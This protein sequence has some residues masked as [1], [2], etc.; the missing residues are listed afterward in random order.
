MEQTHMDELTPRML[1]TEALETPLGIDVRQP[2]LSWQVVAPGRG[3]RQSGYQVQVTCTDSFDGE[4][5]LLW[6]SGH[7]QSDALSLTLPATWVAD[8]GQRYHWRVRVWDQGGRCSGWSAAS[9]WEMGLLDAQEWKADWIEAGWDE[10]PK[11]LHPCPFLR[12]PFRLEK[13]VRTARLL[14][15]AHG[16]YEA[17]LNGQRVGDQLFTP[18]YTAYNERLQY[19]VYDV[20]A[21][22]QPGENVLG[23]ILGDGWYRGRIY[24]AGSRNVYGTRL[25]LLAQ[26]QLVLADGSTQVVG[27]DAGWRAT[28]GP[29]IKSDMREGEIYDAR[30][31]LPGWCVAGYDAAA[32][33]G[34]RVV[35]RPSHR[36]VASLGVPV[37]RQERFPPQILHT[38]NGETVLDFGQNLAGVVRMTVRGPAGTVVRLSHG[39]TLGKDGNF[40]VD[41]L[42]VGNPKRQPPFQEICY[43][44]KGD[45]E[46]TYEP[47]FTVHG[48]RYVKL[49]GHPGDPQPHDFCAVA[50]YSDMP[51]TGHFTC[52][53]P[54]L[55]QL[56]HNVQWSMKGNFLD[57]PTDCPQRERAGWTGD[58]QIFA[59]SASLLMDT[60]AFL[61]KWLQD[62]CL[63]QLPNGMVGNFVPNPY[64]VAQEP[65]A[66]FL[67]LIN[68][69]AGWGDVTTLMPWALYQAY[70][71]VRL[72]E[73][74]YASMQKWLDYVQTRARQVNW[75]RRLHPRFWSNPQTRERQQW[76]WD[77][78]Y[79]WGEW[80]E[81]GDGSQLKVAAGMLQRLILGAPEVATA[82]YARSAQVL[83]WTAAALDRQT[84]ADR[85]QRL[86]D[87]VKTVYCEEFVGPDGRIEPDR[88]ASY[89]RVLAFDLVPAAL[90]PAVAGH[91]VRLIRAAGNHIGT[92]FLS[93][94]L[95][96]P[97]L[98][99][100]GYLDVAYDLLMQTTIPSWLYAVTQGATTVW[101]TW[102]GIGPDGTPQ[103]SLNHYSPGAVVEFLYRKVAGIEAAEPGYRQISIRPLPGGGLQSARAT[104]ASTRGLI[105]SGW[106]IEAGQLQMEVTVP[107]N[108]WATVQLP[109]ARLETVRESDLPLTAAPGVSHPVQVGADTR[110]E[111]GA[112]NYWFSYPYRPARQPT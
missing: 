65:L 13:P 54:L 101:E 24:V 1:R 108:A 2:Q 66:H 39:E 100:Q 61:G 104:Y 75:A 73:R 81:P 57:I 92:G 68:G 7:V 50:I 94:V 16:L 53:E 56:H 12:R 28:T 10:D 97:V 96:C 26:L 37:R 88:Q 71:D 80:L 48:F 62:L 38:P 74:Q 109:N 89:V 84:E 47:R 30:R 46:E 43:I 83:A 31:E 21:L 59:P 51:S 67:N 49:E 77:T 4:Q 18:G 5:G 60:R 20:T 55:N 86:A 9:W 14:I 33:Q 42:L 70:G 3:A 25:A 112:G 98:A 107:A 63:E 64:R 11:I 23:A 22:L 19:Q 34:V 110:L 36:L 99:E 103:M 111:V 6:D 41:H 40:T 106:S 95:L 91:L 45:G 82:Y 58:A 69:S 76:I 52:S 79:Q 32:W 29:L 105:V 15:T 90:K 27:S 17:W 102:E 85:Y 93:T 87:Q 44:L 72:L 8:S 35:P 78:G